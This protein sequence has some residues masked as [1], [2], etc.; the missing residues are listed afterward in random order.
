MNA[1]ELYAIVCQKE[2]ERLKKDKEVAESASRETICKFKYD[3]EKEYSH[4]REYLFVKYFVLELSINDKLPRNHPIAIK[5]RK[6][7]KR[8]NP[9]INYIKLFIEY[10]KEY[11]LRYP[12]YDKKPSTPPKDRRSIPIIHDDTNPT[13]KFYLKHQGGYKNHLDDNKND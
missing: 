8:Y 2:A 9:N 10:D 5:I 7:C 11:R 6:A 13:I 1:F 12:Y 4:Y 3:T